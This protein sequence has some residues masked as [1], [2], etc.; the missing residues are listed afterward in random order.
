M[1]TANSNFRIEVLPGLS[2]ST[3]EVTN[4]VWG[5]KQVKMHIRELFTGWP[6]TLCHTVSRWHAHRE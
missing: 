2:K 1:A 6:P 3:R 4:I 5:L